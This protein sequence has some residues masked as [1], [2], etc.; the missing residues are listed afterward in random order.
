MEED[1]HSILEGVTSLLILMTKFDV[2]TIIW[3]DSNICQVFSIG[4]LQN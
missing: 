4:L 3:W 1:V 2:I